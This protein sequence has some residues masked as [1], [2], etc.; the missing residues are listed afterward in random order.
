MQDVLD[1]TLT[2]TVWLRHFQSSLDWYRIVRWVKIFFR[3]G[4]SAIR[5]FFIAGEISSRVHPR[6]R[7]FSFMIV[8]NF[9][10][11][12]ANRWWQTKRFDN[13]KPWGCESMSIFCSVYRTPTYP[14]QMILNS[15][16]IPSNFYS[17]HAELPPKFTPAM[18]VCH[19]YETQEGKAEWW[20]IIDLQVWK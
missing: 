7:L 9:K 17:E 4:Y 14:C 3:L 10:I 20:S 19:W 15:K 18:K 8:C 11:D 13:K 5:S 6:C 12:L 16:Q 2:I 1:P